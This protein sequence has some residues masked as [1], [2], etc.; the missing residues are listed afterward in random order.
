MIV[1]ILFFLF[2]SE[3]SSSIIQ[4]LLSTIPKT[5]LSLHKKNE[6]NYSCPYNKNKKNL[7][8]PFPNVSTCPLLTPKDI[9]QQL[10]SLNHDDNHTNTITSNTIDQINVIEIFEPPESVE[11]NDKSGMNHEISATDGHHN[12]DSVMNPYQDI[13]CY[14]REFLAKPHPGSGR[15]GPVCPFMPGALR[16]NTIYMS[17]L[18]TGQLQNKDKVSMRKFIRRFLD[19]FLSLE[20]TSGTRRKFKTL[21]LIFPDILANDAKHFIDD[22]QRACKIDFVRKGLMLGEFHLQ[23][24]VRF[25][26]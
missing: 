9:D 24:N 6:S 2:D 23:N 4:K 3:E 22:T 10:Q 8:N 16:R 25:Q 1:A 17:V 26:N 19:R 21:I 11:N 15:S 12:F 13:L 14:L 5:I 7:E 18:H 20:P